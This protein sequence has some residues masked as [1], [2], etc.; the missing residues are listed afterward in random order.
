MEEYL[1]WILGFL[2]LAFLV[3]MVIFLFTGDSS[4]SV[5]ADSKIISDSNEEENEYD[6]GPRTTSRGW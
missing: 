6:E 1:I 2:G 5:S 3:L 4:I